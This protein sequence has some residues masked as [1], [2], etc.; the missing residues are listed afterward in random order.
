MGFSGG[1]IFGLRFG[2]LRHALT[3]VS[4]QY[5]DENST[6][7]LGQFEFVELAYTAAKLFVEKMSLDLEEWLG[8]WAG[9]VLCV[10]YVATM[11]EWEV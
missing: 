10:K 5:I 6:E 3:A 9:R 2:H 4:I 7:R 1:G 11:A 8:M